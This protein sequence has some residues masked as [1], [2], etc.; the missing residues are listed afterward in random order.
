[1]APISLEPDME[2]AKVFWTGRSQAVRL[3]RQFRF[4]TDEVQIRRRG[5]AVILEPIVRDWAWLDSLA[6]P[7]DDD[8]AVA[9]IEQPGEQRRPELDDF[10]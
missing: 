2:T 1:M 3:P 10:D 5:S 8:A 4:D 9:A 6:G 7:L